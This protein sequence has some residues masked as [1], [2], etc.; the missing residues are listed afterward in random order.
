MYTIFFSSL[1]RYFLFYLNA[2]LIFFHPRS[3]SPTLLLT[4]HAPFHPFSHLF[5][6][7]FLTFFTVIVSIFS[8][9]AFV[10]EFLNSLIQLTFTISTRGAMV[11]YNPSKVVVRVRSPASAV[12]F[13]VFVFFNHQILKFVP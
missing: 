1:I 4:T 5:P 10:N 12:F 2:Y 3:F 6:S 11:A 8:C 7:S 9:R 13:Y